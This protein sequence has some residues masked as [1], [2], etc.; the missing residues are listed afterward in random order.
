[1]I[2]CSNTISSLLLQVFT[3]GLS[4][5]ALILM[6]V[7]FLQMH[8]RPDTKTPRANLGVLLI[9]FFE[10]YG[11]QFNYSQTAI[12]VKDG[13]SYVPREQI[14]RNMNQHVNTTPGLTLCIEDPL[15]AKNDVGRG[16]FLFYRVKA[17]FE[18][19]Y[20]T[21]TNKIRSETLSTKR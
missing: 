15:D 11:R 7:S 3:G 12:R 1:M 5:Y 4:S 21:L 20:T 9:E 8:P 18:E 13:G 17:A 19:A 10:L 14:M 6:A 16:S 2:I